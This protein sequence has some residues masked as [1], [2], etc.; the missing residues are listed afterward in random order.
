M[1]LIKTS[2]DA[3]LKPL[4]N[5]VGIVERKHTLPILSNVLLRKEGDALH[6]LATDVEIQITTQTFAE[7]GES[8]S[9]TVAARKLLDI[10]KALPEGN[11]VILN[12]DAKKLTVQSGKA[13]FSVQTLEAADFPTMKAPVEWAAEWTMSQKALK[14]LLGQVFFSMAQQDIRY[15]LNGLLLSIDGNMLR[16]VATDGHRLAYYEKDLN[17]NDLDNKEGKES[18]DTHQAHKE[19]NLPKLD[20]IIPRKTV[21]E[22]MRQLDDSEA[23]I[24]IK[25]TA[26]I[27]QFEFFGHTIM[28][29]L[30][31]GKFPDFNKVLPKNHPKIIDI[32]RA[33][34]QSALHRAAI[35]TTDKFKGVKFALDAN[36]LT[37][38]ANNADQEEASDE[39]DVHYDDEAMDIG[40]NV[41]YLLDV[42]ANLKV[43]TVQLHFNDSNSSSMLTV[44]ND[45]KFKYVVMP[46]RI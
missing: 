25:A 15:Y 7:M 45:N 1:Q 33:V 2:R 42:L 5:C 4:A 10:V 22:M 34:L 11:E 35:M 23:Q 40:F 24:T 16:T 20:L 19:Y 13:R 39:L 28:S 31:E 12:Y 32:S 8:C 37:V 6:F 21:L 17:D 41:N 3:I 44:L 14:N 18:K 46:M 29:K 27:I 26:Q 36:K 38:S 9:T 30:I 43:E